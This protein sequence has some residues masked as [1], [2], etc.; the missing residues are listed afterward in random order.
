MRNP[1]R[2]SI[3]LLVFV[4]VYAF[5]GCR[6][7]VT[8]NEHIIFADSFDDAS[9]WEVSPPVTIYPSGVVEILNGQMDM[10][11]EGCVETYATAQFPSNIDLSDGYRKLTVELT[12]WQ[13]YAGDWGKAKVFVYIDDLELEIAGNKG[14]GEPNC[15]NFQVTVLLKNNRVVKV[16]CA[17]EDIECTARSNTSNRN[18]VYVY[19]KSSHQAD[20]LASAYFSLADIKIYAK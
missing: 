1:T 3:T 9:K 7:H 11:L 18:E 5:A 14:T 6:K 13:Q 20:C 2:L 16:D 15:G 4:L 10:Q 19:M 17:S 12:G 8:D